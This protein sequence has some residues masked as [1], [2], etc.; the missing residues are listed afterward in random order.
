LS[1]RW[2]GVGRINY[3]MDEHRWIEAL[4]GFEY[5]ADCWI[6]RFVAQSFAT[7]IQSTTTTYFFQI[8]LNGLASVGTSP[9]EQLRRTI[10][11]YQKISPPATSFGRFS[12]YE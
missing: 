7:T 4:A 1:R 9:V 10:P 2:Y 11:G 6:G 3:A 5:K 8:E 12:D